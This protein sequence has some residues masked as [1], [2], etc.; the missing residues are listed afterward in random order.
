MKL[1]TFTGW[2][3]YGLFVVAVA[4]LGMFLVAA[5]YGHGALAILAGCVCVVAIATAMGLVGGVVKHDHRIHR[6][7]PRLL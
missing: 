3:A 6:D 2:A 7:T 1:N 4:S 5:G